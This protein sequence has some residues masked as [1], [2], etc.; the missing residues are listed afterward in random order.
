MIKARILQY[1]EYKSISKY[2]FYKLTGLSN[3]F[4]DKEG[5]I[6]SDKCALIID[7]FPDISLY[8]LITGNGNMIF[9][10]NKLRI[11]PD[12]VKDSNIVDIFLRMIENK[13]KKIEELN[14]IIGRLSV[15]SYQIDNEDST[16]IAAEP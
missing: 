8:W 9:D 1:I 14:R 10:K 2:E 12:A 15:R 7:V 11:K 5:A 13:D 6:G 3:G 4:L 16:P